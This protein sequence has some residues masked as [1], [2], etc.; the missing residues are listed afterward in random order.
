MDLQ[1]ADQHEDFLGAAELGIEGVHQH[2]GISDIYGKLC[3][4]LALF[5]ELEVLVYEFIG[6]EDV[7]CL[8]E[9][10]FFRFFQHIKRNDVLNAQTFEF[11][12]KVA[13]IYPQYLRRKSI[14]HSIVSCLLIR[15]EALSISDSSSPSSSLIRTTFSARHDDHLIDACLPIKHL[16]LHIPAIHHILHFWNSDRTFCDICSQDHLSIVAPLEDKVLILRA[17]LGVKW[18]HL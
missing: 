9:L 18:K 6:E 10:F 3:D 11:Q 7:Y 1:H 12:Y 16:N 4:S 17:H 2:A 8:C 15:S 13:E 5:C 14:R